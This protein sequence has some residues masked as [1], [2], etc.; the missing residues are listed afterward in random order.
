MEEAAQINRVAGKKLTKLRDDFLKDLER[1]PGKDSIPV[2]QFREQV[3]S[4]VN[5]DSDGPA[6][7]TP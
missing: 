5:P 7:R 2:R 6:T 1:L 3:I 4:L